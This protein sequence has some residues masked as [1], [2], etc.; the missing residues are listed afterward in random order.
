VRP[1]RWW[2]YAIIA[3]SVLAGTVLYLWTR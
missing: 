2:G 3:V 1:W